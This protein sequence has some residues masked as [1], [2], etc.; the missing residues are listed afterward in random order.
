M[1]V[2][3]KTQ[4]RENY[5]TPDDPYWKFKGGSVFVIENLS[6]RQ[7]K[8]AE[9]TVCPNL[10]QL[11]EYSSA[12]GEEYFL[13]VQAVEDSECPWDEWEEPIKLTYENGKWFAVETET[14]GAYSY[15]NKK[16]A[17]IERR[18]TLVR[19]GERADYRVRYTLVNGQEAYTEDQLKL[20]LAA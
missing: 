2:V 3:I 18:Y 17:K 7:A 5:G 19:K 12:M 16:I 4:Y 9:D 11:I 8:R 15:L 13:S 6:E 1:K 20:A 10:R 14:N